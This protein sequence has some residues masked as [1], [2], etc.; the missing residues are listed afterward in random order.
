[1]SRLSSGRRGIFT[2]TSLQLQLGNISPPFT[3]LTMTG[4]SPND[5]I[6]FRQSGEAPEICYSFFQEVKKW[7]EGKRRRGKAAREQK[8]DLAALERARSHERTR[9]RTAAAMSDGPTHFVSFSRTEGK[10]R[11]GNSFHHLPTM[12]PIHTRTSRSSR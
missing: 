4:G 1:M 6:P 2:P 3:L 9:R 8:S 10:K 5:G 7:S 11:K 12:I